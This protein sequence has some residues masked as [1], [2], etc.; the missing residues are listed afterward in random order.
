MTRWL[1]DGMNVIGSRPDK[2]WNDPDKAVRRMIDELDRYAEETGDDVTVV[3]DR[4]PRDV[5]PGTHGAI[6][7]A[8][9]S[10]RGRNAADHEIDEMVANDEAPASFTVVT[11][12]RDLADRVR[13]RGA[14]V[15]SSGSFRRRL[16][17]V[18]EGRPG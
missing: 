2:W 7:V 17:E 12:D 13:Q 1:V 3:F 6:K 11:S 18:L 14:R 15:A 5:S 10:R 16:D 4:Q 9:A 8:F